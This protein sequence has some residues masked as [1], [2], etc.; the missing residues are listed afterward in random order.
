MK[1]N[2]KVY[3]KKQSN[4]FHSVRWSFV[5]FLVTSWPRVYRIFSP[6]RQKISIPFPI[7]AFS[8]SLLP[9]IW[10]VVGSKHLSWSFGYLESTEN[11]Y[12]LVNP[13]KLRALC[14]MQII[15]EKKS[16]FHYVW[17]VYQKYW[18]VLLSNFLSIRAELKSF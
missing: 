3:R 7:L 10:Q 11:T 1:Q 14:L 16:R 8:F 5:M 18:L 17:N 4:I 13:T 9:P 12:T 15:T 2:L 6:Q